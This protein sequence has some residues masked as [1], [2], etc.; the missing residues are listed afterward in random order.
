MFTEEM[1]SRFIYI[2]FSHV[3]R[4]PSSHYNQQLTGNAQGSF[5]VSFHTKVDTYFLNTV[6]VTARIL[7]CILYV[8]MDVT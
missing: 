1:Y 3:G 6:A 2:M 8:R 7:P 5:I 4:L